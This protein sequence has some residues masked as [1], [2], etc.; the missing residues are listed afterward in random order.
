[1]NKQAQDKQAQ[2]DQE[3]VERLIDRDLVYQGKTYALWLDHVQLPNGF[4]ASREHLHHPGGVAVLAIDAQNRC[5]MVRQYRLPIFQVT[6]EIPAGKLDKLPNET[7]EHA[8]LRELREETGYTAKQLTSLGHIYPSPGVVDE[9]LY[10]FLARELD[11]G[12]QELDED[13]FIQTEW[14][15]LAEMEERIASGEIKDVK[16]ICAFCRAKL[17]RLL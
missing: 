15:P 4:Q 3:L 2:G 5:A 13:E 10:L 9:V 17:M 12:D 1:M 16:A 6:L 8:A 11:K 14:V 7:R